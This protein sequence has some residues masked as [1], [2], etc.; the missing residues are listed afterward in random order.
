MV[1]C[2]LTPMT[3]LIGA[4]YLFFRDRRSMGAGRS[5]TP[6]GILVGH[7]EDITYVTSKGDNRYLASNG[8]DQKMSLWDLRKMYSKQDS[9]KL[10][11][12][13]ETGF[14]YR[15]DRYTRRK[16]YQLSVWVCPL[17]LWKR[18][19]FPLAIPV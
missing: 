12:I 11:K 1:N 15:S 4:L 18:R 19:A 5:C 9:E 17:Y 14:D 3:G 6:S 8:K 10:P 16:S 7:S 2:T 13:G